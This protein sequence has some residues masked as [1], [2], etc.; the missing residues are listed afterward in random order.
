MYEMECAEFE[1]LCSRAADC[2]EACG[3]PAETT[4]V[5][6]L[7]ID[8][9][10]RYGNIAVRGL[11]CHSCNSLIG[12]LESGPSRAT[13]VERLRFDTYL[14]RSW[15]LQVVRWGRAYSDHLASAAKERG[16][17]SSILRSS[18]IRPLTEAAG[19][20]PQVDLIP[21]VAPGPI[22]LK[23]VVTHEILDLRN[24]S[25]S[26]T[27]QCAKQRNLS[28]QSVTLSRNGP[29]DRFTYTS[30]AAARIKALR[31]GAATAP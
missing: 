17:L 16:I 13:D 4:K 23:V 7:V 14:R 29:T 18:F 30:E 10:H 8:H 3:I 31:R 21:V 26:T 5:G 19:Q 24:Y 9:D 6:R 25:V 2:C 22:R 12:A 1:A 15:F 27:L 28:L 11:L 20:Q